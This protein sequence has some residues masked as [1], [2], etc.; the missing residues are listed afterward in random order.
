MIRWPSEFQK[1][2]F[3]KCIETEVNEIF[4]SIKSDPDLLRE[5]R[6]VDKQDIFLFAKEIM[7]QKDVI[8]FE[9]A[10]RERSLVEIAAGEADITKLLSRT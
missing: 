7:G 5:I 9:E 10:P 1:S 8:C 3:P 6:G 2:I 4:K